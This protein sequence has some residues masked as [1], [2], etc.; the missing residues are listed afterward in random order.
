MNKNLL[1]FFK[2]NKNNNDN[3]IIFANSRLSE[4]HF[5]LIKL[6]YKSILIFNADNKTNVNLKTSKFKF[7]NSIEERYLNIDDTANL[8]MLSHL[9]NNIKNLKVLIYGGQPSHVT[10]QYYIFKQITNQN[11]IYV[12]SFGKYIDN[13]HKNLLNEA[14]DGYVHN[15]LRDI[16]TFGFEVFS[17]T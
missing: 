2:K 5:S 7:H 10:S 3:L 4:K 11:N 15:F 17:E 1:N 14:Y 16:S 12:F 9:F 13:F 8:M 6:K